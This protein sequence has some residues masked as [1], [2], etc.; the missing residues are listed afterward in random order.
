MSMTKPIALSVNAFDS[1]NSSVLKFV[2]N[3]GNQ[4]VKNKITIR[5]NSD[6]SVVY[7]NTIESF[8]FEQ[9][10]PPNTLTNGN[11]Y[12]F[13]FNTYDKDDNE[14]E[15]SNI[16]SFYCYTSPTFKITNI[17]LNNIINYSNFIF[18]ATYSQE[19]EELVYF[20]KF[21]LYDG[22]KNIIFESKE[23]YNSS[24]PPFNVSYEING[25]DDDKSYKIEAIAYT[26]NGTYVTS[27]VYD[28]SVNYFYPSI[29]SILDLNNV[30]EDGYIEITNNM[31]LI[32]G[33]SNPDPITYLDET[34]VDLK[35]NGNYVK[36]EKGYVLKNDFLVRGF[37][38][39]ANVGENI[40]ILIMKNS[41]KNDYIV[42]NVLQETYG[43]NK[44]KYFLELRTFVGNINYY[45]ISE[46]T[47]SINH[48]MFWI[49]RINNIYEVKLGVLD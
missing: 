35:A 2:S 38:Y 5:L 1:T 6:N 12:N 44:G 10:I 13:Y 36:W 42:L 7:T 40:K 41:S 33:E 19:Q 24:I 4:V 45:T 21:I 11:Y 9:I 37:I 15:N 18:Q 23:L 29:Y 27:G 43:E 16:I 48:L 46:Y 49:K 28:F 3:G 17:P 26:I 32:D 20:Y 22:N 39:N 25:L 30:C 14:S 47:S 8:K 34:K 31:I